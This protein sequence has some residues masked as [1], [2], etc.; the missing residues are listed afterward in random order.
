[1]PG[2]TSYADSMTVAYSVK[3]FGRNAVLS[4]VLTAGQ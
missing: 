3:G 4:L 1:V 2:I